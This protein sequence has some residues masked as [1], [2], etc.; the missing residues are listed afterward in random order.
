MFLRVLKNAN[1]AVAF[2]LELAVLAAF[3]YWGF[4]T[5]EGTLVKIGLGIGTPVLAVLVWAI[6]GARRATRRL[7]GLWLLLLRVV[8]F[9][10]AAVVLFA[11]SLRVLSIVFALI[12]VI[13]LTLI[14]VWDQ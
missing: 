4:S 3:G 14:Y 13:N 2:F 12:F 9:G 10:S 11:S 5:G 7:Q 8:F 6:F 1:L